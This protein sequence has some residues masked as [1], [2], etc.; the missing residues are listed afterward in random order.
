MITI[1]YRLP[2][3]TGK[4]LMRRIKAENERIQT[5][6]ISQQEEIEVAVELLKEGAW[7]YLV[8]SNDITGRL[9][10]SVQRCREHMSLRQEVVELRQEV[11][12][13]FALQSGV[14][15]ESEAMKRVYGQLIKAAETN[16]TVMISGETGTGKEVA[17]KA[18][19]FHSKR[20]HKP[21]VAVNVTAI[22]SELVESELFGHEKGAFTGAANKRVGRFE[23][24]MGGTLFLDEVGDMDLSMQAKLLRVLQEKEITRVGGG[25]VIKVD[26]RIIVATH[27][28]LKEAV[29]EG[30]FRE[31]LYYR[32]YG[33][34]LEMPPLRERG[35]DI[36][37]LSRKFIDHFC[38]ENEIKPK[39]LSSGAQQKLLA[40]KFPGNVRELKSIV[41]LS[42]VTSAGEVIQPDEIRLPQEEFFPQL[43]GEQ[44]TLR[45]YSYRI[46]RHHLERHDHEIPKVAKLLDI[47]S[48][49]I[50]RMLKEMQDGRE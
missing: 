47:S 35:N 45:E 29:K 30:R 33:F 31:D 5:L 46:L 13:K 36:L 23:E 34:P 38:K 9:L 43:M 7:D 21:F 4:E 12:N 20:S 28:N 19:H 24:A 10:A 18:I 26:C 39:S 14:V 6:V 1:D 3:M 15:G 42:A 44:M 2:D 50:Y 11:G 32:L 8:K 37:L 40:Y 48:A 25:K 41:E 27:R 17:A 49:T 16:I 22:P